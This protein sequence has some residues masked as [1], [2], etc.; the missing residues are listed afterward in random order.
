MTEKTHDLTYGEIK[1]LLISV[2]GRM[3]YDEL[4]DF[5]GEV[6]ELLR[7]KSYAKGYSEGFTDG[8]LEVGNETKVIRNL[9]TEYTPLTRDEVV[10]KA[11][12]DLDGLF[13]DGF[14]GV[15]K[16][17][18]ANIGGH[19][20]VEFIVN[21]E[22][23]TVVALLRLAYY[24]ADRIIFKGIA[25][26]APNDCFTEDIGKAIALRRALGLEVPEEYLD[27]PEPEGV[28][29]GDIITLPKGIGKYTVMV[30]RDNGAYLL[31]REKGTVYTIPTLSNA[32]VI[33]DSARYKDGES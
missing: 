25:K 11:K 29:V 18:K 31:K 1:S 6:T 22:K 17:V 16:V 14:N 33:D 12:A 3:D 32:K 26:C 9:C 13:E 24:G 30:E 5:S 27:A 4:K 23:R 19:C 10:A 8:K 21:R 28:E 20:T 15:G 7:I 2:A